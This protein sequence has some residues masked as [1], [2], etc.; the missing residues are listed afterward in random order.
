M[1]P[2]TTQPLRVLDGESARAQAWIGT[3][4]DAVRPLADAGRPAGRDR[5]TTKAPGR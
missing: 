4:L 3:V 1:D 5:G 2:S